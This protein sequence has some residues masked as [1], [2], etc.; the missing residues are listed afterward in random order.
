MNPIAIAN[1]AIRQ[2]ADGRFSLNDLHQ[3][4]GAAKRHQ[5]SDFLRSAQTQ[6]L[7]AELNSGESRNYAVARRPGRGGGTFA[8]K[9]M[10]YAYAMWISPAFCV[11]VI[12]AYDAGEMGKRFLSPWEEMEALNLRDTET[13]V[14]ASVGAT[15]MND[16]KRELPALRRERARLEQEIQPSLFALQRAMQGDGRR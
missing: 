1:K 10:V 15:W 7:I 6:E 2:D 16:R 14:R 12:R 9:E 5:P 8:C 13:K 4:A 3:A 11:K